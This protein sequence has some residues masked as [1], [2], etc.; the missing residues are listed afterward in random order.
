MPVD[1][2]LVI[3]IDRTGMAGSP[4]A[5]VFRGTRGT[6]SLGI[7]GYTEPAEE[8]LNRYATKSDYDDGQEPRGA[9]MLNSILGLDFTTDAAASEAASRLLIAEVRLAIRRLRYAV[10][11]TTAGATAEVWAVRGYG[12]LTPAGPRSY[13]DLKGHN[14]VWSLSLPVNPNRTIT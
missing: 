12:S 14:P 7:V 9:T 4:A 6:G 3:S 2:S 11:V 10:T 8:P 5:L 1:T 13:A